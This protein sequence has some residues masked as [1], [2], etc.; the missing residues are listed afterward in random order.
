M[1]EAKL[2][3]VCPQTLW[4]ANLAINKKGIIYFDLIWS[5]INI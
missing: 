2:E 4:L 1:D 3:A 5:R